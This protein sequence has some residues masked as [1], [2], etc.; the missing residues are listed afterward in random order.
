MRTVLRNKLLKDTTI[1]ISV[2]KPTELFY[3]YKTE[4]G[5]KNPPILK[6]FSRL[7]FECQVIK[8]LEF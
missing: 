6:C 2:D 3:G 5:T 1:F 8:E 7:L 4:E